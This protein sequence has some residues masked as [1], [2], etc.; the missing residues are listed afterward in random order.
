MPPNAMRAN[1]NA[2]VP[3]NAYPTIGCVTANTTVANSIHPMRQIVSI[4]NI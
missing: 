1:F 4:T 2:P 3:A